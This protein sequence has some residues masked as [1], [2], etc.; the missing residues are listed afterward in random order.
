MDTLGTRIR[1]ARGSESQESFAAR[2]GVS[3]GALG[4]YERNENLPNSDIILKICSSADISVEWLLTGRNYEH[5]ETEKCSAEGQAEF[6]PSCGP[7]CCDKCLGLYMKLDI[8]H[9]RLFQA[10][11]RERALLTELG[12]L[13]AELS[14]MKS[15]TLSPRTAASTGILTNS[16]S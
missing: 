13:R 9:E 8:A 2:L 7:D 6:P 10:A 14:L 16:H 12:E 5:Q 15:M 11:E 4:G 3:K 1:K